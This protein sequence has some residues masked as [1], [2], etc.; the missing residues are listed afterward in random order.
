MSELLWR[1]GHATTSSVRIQV[2]SDTAGTVTYAGAS[3][4]V[5]TALSTLA[6]DPLV[7]DGTG[8]VVIEGLPADTEFSGVLTCGA[9]TAAIEFKTRRRG[10][11]SMAWIGCVEHPRLEGIDLLLQRQPD[12]VVSLGDFGYNDL[13]YASPNNVFGGET[14]VGYQVDNSESN[15]YKTHRAY[16]RDQNMSKIGHVCDI[17]DMRDDHQI[18]DNWDFSIYRANQ[19]GQTHPAANYTDVNNIFTVLNDCN[20]NYWRS[21]PQNTDSGIDAGAKYVR[22][23]EGWDSVRQQPLVEFFLCDHIAY[24]DIAV[25]IGGDTALD[26]TDPAKAFMGTTQENWLFAKTL[27][28]TATYKVWLFPKQLFWNLS[29]SNQDGFVSYTARKD[30]ITAWAAANNQKILVFCQDRH[31]S[32]VHATGNFLQVTPCP[33]GTRNYEGGQGAGYATEALWKSNGTDSLPADD[34][35]TPAAGYYWD[36]YFGMASFTPEYCTLEIVRV[37]RA[38]TV[39]STRVAPDSVTPVYDEPTI[40]VL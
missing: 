40:M 19:G 6:L 15:C 22:W 36:Q 30:V 31:D 33:V 1:R 14:L 7:E 20:W 34:M 18:E 37:K 11:F 10:N 16:L 21:N 29:A 4:T 3:G 35:L 26:P 27:A 12:F 2:R 23:Q 25:A 13:P 8:V 24:K 9:A 28:S 5:N 39:W 17:I 38:Q 32:S